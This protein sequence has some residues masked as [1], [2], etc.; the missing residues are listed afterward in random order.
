[1]WRKQEKERGGNRLDKV[2]SRHAEVEE[3][4]K[5][6][7]AWT[8]RR[9]LEAVADSETKKRVW[10]RELDKMM[11]EQ[12]SGWEQ[13][14][15]TW[16]EETIKEREEINEIDEGRGYG[17]RVEERS[18][19]SERNRGRRGRTEKRREKNEEREEGTDKGDKRTRRL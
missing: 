16:V 17:S 18:E 15:W 13:K 6:K 4:E 7:N 12:R 3:A 8:M 11:E 14:W 19:S 5:R 10:D 1:M 9:C 2:A